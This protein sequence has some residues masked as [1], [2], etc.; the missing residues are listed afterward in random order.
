[1]H[2]DTYSCTINTYTFMSK[3]I[4]S[5]H[6][7]LFGPDIIDNNNVTEDIFWTVNIK[8]NI[9]SERKLQVF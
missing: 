7:K 2:T 5:I 9:H 4:L 3:C 8:Q 1:M 6:V